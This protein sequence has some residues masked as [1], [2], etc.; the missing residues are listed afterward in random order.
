MYRCPSLAEQQENVAENQKFCLGCCSYIQYTWLENISP[1][2]WNFL[3]YGW[4]GKCLLNRAL[5]DDE[6]VEKFVLD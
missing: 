3:S 5:E 2:Y 4:R 1:A 6:K